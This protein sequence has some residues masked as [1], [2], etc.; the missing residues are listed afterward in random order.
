MNVL[1]GEML[2]ASIAEDRVVRHAYSAALAADLADACDGSVDTGDE[3]EYWGTSE[4]A[5]GLTQGWRV[6]LVRRTERR[7]SW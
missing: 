6:H 3:S 4:D 5:E 1:L 2:A 7:G